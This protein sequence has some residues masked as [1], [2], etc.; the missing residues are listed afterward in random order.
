MEISIVI[1]MYNSEKYIE[2]CLLSV[3]EQTYANYEII[4]IDDC[5]TDNTFEKANNLLKRLNLEGSVIKNPVNLGPGLSRNKG[6]EQSHGKYLLFIDSDDYISNNCLEILYNEIINKSSDIIFCDYY[7]VWENGKKQKCQDLNIEEGY[8]DNFLY[9]SLCNDGVTRKL[10]NKN[11]FINNQISFP[12]WNNG[13]DI[14]VAILLALNS[15]GIYY[16]KK[17]LYNYYQRSDST[18]NAGIKNPDFYKNIFMLFES[19]YNKRMFSKK[20]LYNRLISDLFYNNVLVMLKTKRK[21][22][23]IRL[24]LNDI[25][26]KYPDI[27]DY[28]VLSYYSIVKKLFI[29]L[30][31][32]KSVL[33][34]KLMYKVKL[35]LERNR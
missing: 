34:L 19:E 4:L 6:I 3:K 2:K 16:T 8:V 10:I 26:Q 27:S 28:A 9:A 11:L 12:N 20:Y 35:I 29:N 14:Y 13:E 33:L 25:N 24:Y 30:S 17:C 23:D 1:P 7:K 22:K 32:R 31:I 5:S 18:S 21:A 15:D